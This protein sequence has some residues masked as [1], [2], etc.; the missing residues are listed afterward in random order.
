MLRNA[1]IAMYQAKDAGRGTHRYYTS[2]MNAHTLARLDLE[3]ELRR[4]L[5]REEFVVHYQPII[6]L[7][8][9]KMS[10]A[11]ALVRWVHPEKGLVP[12]GEFIPLLE[13]TGLIA[14]L[15]DWVMKRA[16]QEAR[17][18]R[19]P[20]GKAPRVSVNLSNRQLTLGLKAGDV[21][22]VL[23][24]TGLPADHLTIEITESLVMENVSDM[25]AWLHSVKALGVHISVDDF[26]TGY[27]SLSYLKRFPIDIVKIDRSFIHD[28]TSDQESAALV[29]AIIAMSHSLNLKVVAEGIETLDQQAFLQNLKCDYGQGFYFSRPAPSADM[30]TFL[31]DFRLDRKT[32]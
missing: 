6:D 20:D 23:R 13:E 10:S 18:W 4:A 2:E 22:N 8:S 32:A 25:I 28:V 26:G 9:G 12:P 27:S 7:G 19:G 29:E 3:G 14:P 16:C 15:G 11:E 30:E 31:R 5:E 21:E 1:D 17:D 24:E